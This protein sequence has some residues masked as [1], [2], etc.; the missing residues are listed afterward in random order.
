VGQAS[1]CVTI[2]ADSSLL[3]TES[4]ELVHSVTLSQLENLGSCAAAP[5]PV[6]E[7]AP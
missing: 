3:Q 6:A 1:D 2:S 5:E 4:S 7:K